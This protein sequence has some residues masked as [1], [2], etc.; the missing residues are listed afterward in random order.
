MNKS[1]EGK[2]L[3]RDA[4]RSFTVVYFFASVLNLPYRQTHTDIRFDTCVDCGTSEG[5]MKVRV[6]Q[7]QGSN[8]R[9]FCYA[10]ERG[11]DVL[12]AA[13]IAWQ[14]T[15][16]DAARQLRAPPRECEKLGCEE[17]SH[18]ERSPDSRRRGCCRSGEA[19]H[20]C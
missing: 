6:T 7:K 2:K 17:C 18:F 9:W 19:S 5:S 10:C 3:I 12:D 15:P 14:V 1:D 4:K 13:C 11:G 20:R 16:F 8:E